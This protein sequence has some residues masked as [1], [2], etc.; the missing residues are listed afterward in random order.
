MYAK[1]KDMSRDEL[2]AH[3]KQCAVHRADYMECLHGDKMFGRAT[4]IAKAKA[5]AEGHEH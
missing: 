1:K 5:K 4:A 3:A 2:L